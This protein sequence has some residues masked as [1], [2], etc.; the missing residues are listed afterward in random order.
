MN[1]R[2]PVVLAFVALG[3]MGCCCVVSRP[4][5]PQQMQPLPIIIV[6]P[7]AQAPPGEA[8][9]VVIQVDQPPI[10]IDQAAPPGV[11]PPKAV[12]LTGRWVGKMTQFNSPFHSL[13]VL[14]LNQ[15]GDAVTGNGGNLLPPKASR[16]TL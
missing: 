5:Q 4:K 1:R 9:P 7:Q 14:N 13:F 2:V 8:P 10:I 6:A 12:D 16:P 11:E 15:Q 3:L